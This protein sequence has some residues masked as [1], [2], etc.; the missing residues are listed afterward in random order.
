M[1]ALFKALQVIL[2]LSILI[3]VHEFG[4]FL[5]A[6]LFGIRVEKFYL[7]FDVGGKAL[8]RFR[9]GETEF[10]IGW[11]PFGGYCKIAGM[12]D[13]SVDMNQ[14]K[15]DPQPWEFRTK[16][17]WQRLFVLAGGVL[18]NFIF[19]VIG[20]SVI[21]GIWG[22]AYISNSES[23]IYPN[24]LAREM[25][26]KPGDKI[27]KLDDYVPEDFSMLQAD[28]ARREVRC[29]TILRGQDTV[30]L[31]ID[32][33]MIGEV[34][35]SPYMFDLALPFVVDSVATA[36]NADVLEKGDVVL[37]LDGRDT[38]FLQDA[39]PILA[40]HAGQTI[41]ATV[42]RAGVL[43]EVPLQV[44]TAGRIGIMLNP[45]V[46]K[47]Q[48][49]SGLSAIPAGLRKTGSTIKGYVSDLKM[50]FK[51]STKAY[52]SVGSFIAIGQ[53]FPKTWDW[54]QFLN[55]LALLSIMLGVV[56]LIPIPGLDG[57][58]ILFTLY[59]MISGRKPSDKFLYIMQLIGMV[60]LF[61]LMFLAFGNDI[62]RLI[63]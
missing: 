39:S 6:K 35:N 2:A 25:G 62:M 41:T 40:E 45:P 53:V 12:V 14:L 9:I 3:I 54:Y 17:A 38:R 34:L 57:G 30:R 19:A 59:E 1:V 29:A 43:A 5:F 55:I 24:E 8:V 21:C 22:T 10:G 50:V 36:A 48:S 11:L 47:R 28:L 18:F 58:H 27:L 32:Q 20:Y 46:V 37:Q 56:N 31:Y 44:D 63:R 60:L 15:R 7:F 49:Y 61:A 23:A 51:P 16:P 33:S 4:H 52:K 26:F 42:S 13:E